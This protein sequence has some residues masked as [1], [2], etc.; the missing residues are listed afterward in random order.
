[1]RLYTFF[2]TIVDGYGYISDLREISHAK[3]VLRVKVG[4]QIRLVDGYKE[5]I[6]DIESINAK[7]I[8]AK[9]LTEKEDSYSLNKQ[10][11]GYICLTKGEALSE[12]VRHLTEIGVNELYP[13]I[14]QHSMKHINLERCNLISK[15]GAKQCGAVKAMKIHDKILLHDIQFAKYDLFLF[16]QERSNSNLLTNFVEMIKNS[17]KIAFIIGPE[18]GFSDS[19]INFLSSHSRSVSLGERILRAETAAT[20]LSGFLSIF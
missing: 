14:S 13:V 1:M 20:V 10:I 5:Y 2:G 15:E 9:V 4:D 6:A 11:D 3:S 19:E 17:L 12:T 16:S 7:K 18:G 8:V